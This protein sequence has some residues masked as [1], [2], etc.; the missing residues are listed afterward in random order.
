MNIYQELDRIN[1]DDSLREDIVKEARTGISRELRNYIHDA[2]LEYVTN[3]RI[4]ELKKFNGQ[5]S[6]KKFLCQ[7]CNIKYSNELVVHHIDLDHENYSRSNLCVMQSGLHSHMH[8]V[9]LSEAI[10]LMLQNKEIRTRKEQ[11]L[12]TIEEVNDKDIEFVATMYL[13]K[14][15][16]FIEDHEDQITLLS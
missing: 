7:N 5:T 8:K 12:L 10:I 13:R 4:T 2:T 15:R 6:L 11:H 1:D 9:C 16:E 14:I 3:K